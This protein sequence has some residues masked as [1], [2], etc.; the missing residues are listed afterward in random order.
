MYTFQKKT[1]MLLCLKKYILHDIISRKPLI[2]NM[3]MAVIVIVKYRVLG[4]YEVFVCID[5][6]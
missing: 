3:L 1:L 4:G 2:F 6:L 5:F